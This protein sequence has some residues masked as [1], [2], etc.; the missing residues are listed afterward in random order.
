[1]SV[2]Q[3]AGRSLVEAGLSRACV[4]EYDRDRK[5]AFRW[6][7]PLEAAI[8]NFRGRIATAAFGLTIVA[9]ASDVGTFCAS[10]PCLSNG[11]S[12]HR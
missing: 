7:E 6:T 4:A 5:E 12:V 9:A 3:P 2:P 8:A 1:M 11:S 10:T